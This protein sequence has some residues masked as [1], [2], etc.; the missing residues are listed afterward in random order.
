MTYLL[1]T[2][3][4]I[5]YLNGRS[6]SIFRK[7]DA[8]PESEICVCSIV[9]FELRYGALKSNNVEKTLAEQGR[10]L[11]RFVSLPFDDAAHTHAA[12]VRADLSRS[13]LTDQAV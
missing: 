8:L 7:L 10:F 2:N 6:V 5:R 3:T 13:G 12:R 9:K 4:C 1:D 11:E